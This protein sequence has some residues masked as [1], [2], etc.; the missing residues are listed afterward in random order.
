MHVFIP[1]RIYKEIESYL[2]KRWIVHHELN[3]DIEVF[4]GVS[5]QIKGHLETLNQL[6]YVLLITAGYDTLDVSFLKEKQIKL[7]NAKDVYSIP[8]AEMVVGQILSFNKGLNVYHHQQ[9]NHIWESH[10][11][12]KDLEGSRVGFVGGGSIA[13][14]IL[15]RLKGFNITSS[16]YRRSDEESLFDKTYNTVEGLTLLMTES[17][18]II[19]TLPLNKFT[20]N[21][22][23]KDLLGL[24]H[25]EAFYVNVGRGQT[26][27]ETYLIELLK[28][29]RIRGA[30]LDVF[31]AEP[32]DKASPYWAMKNLVI[33]PHNSSNTPLSD[34]MLMK[35]VIENL[36]NYLSKKELINEIKL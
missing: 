32:I 20:T 5:S 1:K 17:D 24:M 16:V 3:K 23:N 6:K 36:D 35:L 11:N 12:F 22:L 7:T 2:D 29:N 14:E 30:Y 4:V 13:L 18:Y 10:F 31:Q 25:K 9:Y 27:D 21:L 15:K 28:Q 34:Q 26:H 19:N 33:T 8:I